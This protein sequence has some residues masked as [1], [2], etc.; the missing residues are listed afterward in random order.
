[1]Y[2]RFICIPTFLKSIAENEKFNYFIYV[3]YFYLETI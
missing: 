3:K 1:M 2:L